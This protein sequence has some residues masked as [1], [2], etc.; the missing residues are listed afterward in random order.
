MA[1]DKKGFLQYADYI[2]TF[3]ALTDEQAGKLIKHIYRYVNDLD[4]EPEDHLIKMVFLPI[5]KQLQ[6]DL[7]KWEET[8]VGKSKGGKAS[9]AKR[10]KDKASKLK[11]LQDTST[12]S[13]VNDNATVIDT[14][15]DNDIPL[16]EVEVIDPLSFETFWTLYDKKIDKAK[17]EVKWNNLSK[18]DKQLAIN[19]IP[20]YVNS[21]KEKEFRRNP[22]TF[23][24]SK[25]W[26]NELITNQKKDNNEQLR[27]IAKRITNDHPEL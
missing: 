17:C 6:R 10:A 20:G 14:V 27:E 18:S 24:N 4:P 3:E 25:G 2:D 12:D 11:S 1:T 19:Y 13:T 15:N 7:E 9:A 22:A 5:K 23:L 26:E 16:I 21:T 8:R